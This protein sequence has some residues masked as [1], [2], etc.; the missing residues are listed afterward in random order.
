MWSHF[1]HFFSLHPDTEM[2]TKLLIELVFL[3]LSL[4]ILGKALGLCLVFLFVSD[5]VE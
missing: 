3:K 2:Q 5:F 1:S 4:V